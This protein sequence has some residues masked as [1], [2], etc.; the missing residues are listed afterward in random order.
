MKKLYRFLRGKNC[1][2]G[3]EAEEL[4]ICV[5]K[6][7]NNNGQSKVSLKVKVNL[8]RKPLALMLTL[9]FLVGLSGID[10]VFYYVLTLFNGVEMVVEPYSISICLQ[11][12]YNITVIKE[13]I[14]KIC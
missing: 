7:N 6:N 5:K 1:P 14:I 2:V 11:V 13:I 12:L 4:L 3:A 8:L 9:T 10:A